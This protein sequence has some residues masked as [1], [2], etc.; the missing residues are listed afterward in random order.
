MRPKQAP[1]ASVGTKTPG[2]SKKT[3]SA[4]KWQPGFELRGWFAPAGSLIP[5]VTTVRKPLSTIATAIAQTAE[6]ISL[7]F[8]TQRCEGR[9][10]SHSD[11]RTRTSSPPAMCV[12]GLVNDNTAVIKVT[13][14]QAG[15]VVR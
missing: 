8:D 10:G 9:F 2:T 6:R 4:T 3:R 11:T 15:A 14:K 12:R 5:N 13:C 1:T 7:G